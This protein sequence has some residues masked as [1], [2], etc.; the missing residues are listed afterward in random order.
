MRKAAVFLTLCFAAG[1]LGA[2]ERNAISGAGVSSCGQYLETLSDQELSHIHVTWAQGFMSGMNM[3]EYKKDVR[4]FIALPDAP[5]I[6]AYLTKH[7]RENPLDSPL[8]GVM[9]MY[10]EVQRRQDAGL[11]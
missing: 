1:F 7:C 5:T 11:P 4:P 8:I 9:K 10:R 6:E 2:Q 3:A